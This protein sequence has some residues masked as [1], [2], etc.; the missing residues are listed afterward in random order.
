MPGDRVGVI[1]PAGP[2]NRNDLEPGLER[3]ESS[4]FRVCLGPNIYNRKDYLAGDDKARL[5]DLHAMFNDREIKAIF[6]ARGG[7]GS[8]RLLDKIN[9]ELIRENPKILVGFSDITALLLAINRKTGLV[10]LHGPMVGGLTSKDMENWNGLLELVSS[11]RA[12]LVGLTEG[13]ALRPGR[14]T[15]RLIGGN[16]TLICHLIGTPFMPS[17]NHG[18]LFIEER[19][20]TLYRV[21]RML[22]Q[23]RLSGQLEGLSGLMAGRFEACGDTS[24]INRLLVEISSGLDIPVVSGLPVG[25]GMKNQ[26]LPLG[27]PARLD[28]DLMTLSIMEPCIV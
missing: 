28:A 26:A 6:C 3:V 10:T 18:I 12:L 17:L 15:G 11:D 9:F 25:H 14:A 22:T 2:I 19:G 4:G 24:D 20:E 8:L 7:Y 23:L 16:L 5:S 1:A 21:D 27:V 13:I